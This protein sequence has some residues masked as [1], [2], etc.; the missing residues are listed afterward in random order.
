MKVKTKILCYAGRKKCDTK[1]VKQI[2]YTVV[3]MGDG[4]FKKEINNRTSK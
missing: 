4:V 1:S 3:N 2:D